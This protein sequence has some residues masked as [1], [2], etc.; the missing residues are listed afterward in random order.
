MRHAIYSI[1]FVAG[2]CLLFNGCKKD[3]WGWPES[4]EFEKEGGQMTVGTVDGDVAY[5]L[6]IFDGENEV[7]VDLTSL[8]YGEEKSF[9]YEWLTVTVTKMYK[10]MKLVADPNLTGKTRHLKVSGMIMN[11]RYRLVV[12]QK[13]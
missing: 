6:D 2:L 5:L 13:G 8:A 10:S 7:H 3:N 9:Q 12:Y 1:L 11:G 4:V